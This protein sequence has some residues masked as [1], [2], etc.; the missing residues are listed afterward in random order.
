MKKAILPAILLLVGLGIGILLGFTAADARE[1]KAIE[2]RFRDYAAECADEAERAER[3][4]EDAS[5]AVVQ[6]LWMMKAESC[7]AKDGSPLRAFS[8][9]LDTLAYRLSVRGELPEGIYGRIREAMKAYA[10]SGRE[11]VLETELER[12]LHAFE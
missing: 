11:I 3:G 7:A 1:E 6:T 2:A 12:I 10:E 5:L 8:G 9:T 4:G